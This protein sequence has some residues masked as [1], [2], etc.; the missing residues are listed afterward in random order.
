[1]ANKN[2]HI[3]P[4]CH[5]EVPDGS[6]YCPYCNES[7]AESVQQSDDGQ[8]LIDG[9]GNAVSEL[10]N[11]HTDSHNTSV[12]S[13]NTHVTNTTST[14][15]TIIN[16]LSGEAEAQRRK[17]E[18]KA[19]CEPIVK[20]KF[21]TKDDRL[22]LD[23]KAQDLKLTSYEAGEIEQSV[24][25]LAR[26][27]GYMNQIQEVAFKDAVGIL[28]NDGDATKA[29]NALKPLVSANIENDEVLYYYYM[30][31]VLQN[32]STLLREYECRKYFSYWQSFWAYFAYKKNKEESEAN[33]IMQ[34]LP[35]AGDYP[36]GNATLL[37]IADK[38][39]EQIESPSVSFDSNTL[40][41]ILK[42]CGKIS[43]QLKDLQDTVEYALKHIKNGVV[44]MSNSEKHN[45]YLKL[46]GVRR[47]QRPTVEVKPAVE[48]Q[49]AQFSKAGLSDE[50]VNIAD[51]QMRRPVQ[52]ARPS[53]PPVQ[54][55][56]A[57][58]QS[59]YR[60]PTPPPT[61]NTENKEEWWK[62]CIIIIAVIAAIG[63][64]VKSCFSSCSNSSDEGEAD[65]GMIDSVTVSSDEEETNESCT[66]EM[67]STNDG[68]DY[69]SQSEQN[70]V[71]APSQDYPSVSSSESHREETTTKSNV[72]TPSASTTTSSI[73]AEESPKTEASPAPTTA[74]QLLAK[75]KSLDGSSKTIAQAI[76]YYRQAANQGNAEAM[77]R[78]GCAYSFGNAATKDLGQAEKWFNKAISAGEEPW[79]SRSKS[80]KV[81]L[82]LGGM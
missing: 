12:D 55:T 17:D 4:K 5:E 77:Y 79:A 10:H 19:F 76:E 29:L 16:N 32:A 59:S 47:C 45:L 46:L 56:T 60:Q 24:K 61:K 7:Q 42:N 44:P 58:R 64:G 28:E 27:K 15:T 71:S 66:S 67:A 2:V 6:R 62:G 69:Q 40:L 39:Y 38:L 50:A 9:Y 63:W 49:P 43:Q 52:T 57:N 22:R 73:K 35:D 14:N 37:Y 30:A 26:G 48:P 53:V 81:S 72:A 34:A 80:K 3:C 54:Q 70:E 51:R 74:K 31:S 25:R 36:E 82:G 11:I 13:H 20:K 18:Y 21:I 65:Y 68:Q 1:M 23:A 33:R 75:G 78:L 41:S 8:P